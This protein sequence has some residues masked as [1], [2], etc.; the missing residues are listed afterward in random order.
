MKK[1]GLISIIRCELVRA[2]IRPTDKLV[3][4]VSGGSD[5]MALLDGLRQLDQQVVV[6]HVNHGLR[7]EADIDEQLVSRYCQQ[8][9]LELVV[10]RVVLGGHKSGVEER[11]RAARYQALAEVMQSSGAVGVATAHTADDQVETVVANW[12]RGSAIKGL[13]GMRLV[14]GKIIR[15]MLGIRKQQVLDYVKTHRIK[16]A[17]DQS[18]QDTQFTRNRIRHELLPILRKYNPQFDAQMWHNAQVWQQADQAVAELAGS[19]L[20]RVG[21]K[22]RD[23]WVVSVSKMQELTWLMQGEVIKVAMGNEMVNMERTHFEEAM[24]ILTSPRSVVAKRRL[25]G[26]LF[27]GKSHDK[28]TIS[29]R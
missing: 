29:H 27:M 21:K 12:L 22:T 9:G 1:Q 13:G 10:K 18:N 19:Y 11:A 28:I 4:A 15:P 14:S 8:H 3:A 26:K 7:R 23:G 20:T 5:S 6:V 24:K 25:G 17:T 2:G 16:F